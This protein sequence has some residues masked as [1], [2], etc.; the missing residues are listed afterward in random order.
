MFINYVFKIYRNVIYKLYVIKYRNVFWDGLKP[1]LTIDF[2]EF[3]RILVEIVCTYF[4]MNGI[5]VG[6]L[7][8]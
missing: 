7:G 8:Y 2:V 1:I 3:K 6:R 5:L 4:K